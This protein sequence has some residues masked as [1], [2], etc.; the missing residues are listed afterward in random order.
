MTGSREFFSCCV[1]GAVSDFRQHVNAK[2]MFGDGY[3]PLHVAAMTGAPTEVL[4]YLV[5]IGADVHAKA[6]NGW[7]PLH[8]AAA[9]K[10]NVEVLKCLVSHGSDINAK[11]DM[12]WA[13]VHV[14]GLFDSNGRNIE[15]L[16]DL[17]AELFEVSVGPYGMDMRPMIVVKL[18]SMR[19]HMEKMILQTIQIRAEQKK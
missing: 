9:T 8:F 14:A 18:E 11:D 15:C 5:S 10:D 2:P 1:L 4:K 6:L 16:V 17:G 3:T 7:T 12:G 19:E 13:P